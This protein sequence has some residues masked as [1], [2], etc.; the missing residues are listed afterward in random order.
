MS[1]L[2]SLNLLACGLELIPFWVSSLSSGTLGFQNLQVQGQNP[3]CWVWMKG[4]LGITL[5]MA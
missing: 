3:S 2:N 5:H 1:L 4:V